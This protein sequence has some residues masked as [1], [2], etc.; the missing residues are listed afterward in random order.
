MEI[1]K[2]YDNFPVRIVIISNLVSILIYASGLVIMLRSGW[3]PAI[4][5]MTFVIALEYRLISKHC[6]NCY[7]WNKT[8]GFG[9]GRVSAFFFK[10]GDSLK[11]CEKEMSWKE[12][13]PD[14]LISLIPLMAGIVLMIIRFD[15]VLFFASIL[16]IT[17]P[18]FGNAFIRGNLTCRY[19]K[20]RETGCPAEKLFNRKT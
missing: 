8:C 13:I 20:Q 9:K 7:Y 2:T 15:F 4:F 16:L 11:F 18:T 14:L 19:C 3:L 17:L 5:Y 10:Q 12:L 1:S 6:V